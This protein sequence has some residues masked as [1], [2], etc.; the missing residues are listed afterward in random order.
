M[1]NRPIPDK[2][3]LE[4]ISHADTRK[5][6]EKLCKKTAGNPTVSAYMR[7][8]LETHISKECKDSKNA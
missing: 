5:K 6:Y 8:V 7:W 4:N 2:G 1:N 3:Y